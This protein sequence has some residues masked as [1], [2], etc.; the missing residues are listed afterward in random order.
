MFRNTNL[1]KILLGVIAACAVV[2]LIGFSTNSFSPNR[3]KKIEIKIKNGDEQFFIEQQE[4][5]DLATKYGSDQLVG[6]LYEKIDLREIEQRVLRNRQ[7]RSCQA[8][9]G[10]E[11]ILNINIEQ[12]IPVA[13]IIMPDGRD[14][15]Y[16]N[17]EGNFFPLSNRYS[18][19]ILL[20]SGEYFRNLLGLKE[21][22]HQ[23]SLQFINYINE[24]PFLK[25]QF[26]QLDIDANGNIRIVPL[27]GKHII[28]FGEPTNIENR[29]NRLKIFYNQILPVKGWDSFTWVSVKYNG[30]IV[31]K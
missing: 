3:C 14:D 5:E 1:G 22:R 30:Q 24:D 13:R 29:L 25:A 28:E 21:I 2:F 12:Q 8:F 31:C 4:V 15:V 6:K 19:R 9:R 7:I 23:R 26:S 18:A 20:L 11:G 10:I 17:T 27:L 16:I